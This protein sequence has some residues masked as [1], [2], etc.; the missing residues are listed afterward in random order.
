MKTKLEI[1]LGTRPIFSEEIDVVEGGGERSLLLRVS[2]RLSL[3]VSDA[4]ELLSRG[5]AWRSVLLDNVRAHILDDLT[6]PR[7]EAITFKIERKHRTSDPWKGC[8][9]GDSVEVSALRGKERVGG[10]TVRSITGNGVESGEAFVEFSVVVQKRYRRIGVGSRLYQIAAANLPGPLFP[11][12]D[13]SHLAEFT[14]EKLRREGLVRE[15]VSPFGG[16]S[17][18][19]SPYLCRSNPLPELGGRA[20][21][22]ILEQPRPKGQGSEILP[23]LLSFFS[24]PEGAWLRADLEA[25]TKKGVETYGEPLT[26]ENG[27]DAL[28]DALQEVEDLL[29]YA[30]QIALENEADREA[31]REPRHNAKRVLVVLRMVREFLEGESDAGARL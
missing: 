30:G 15:F 23:F 21:D 20:A 13:H 29:Q 11:D 31:G 7:L 12:P 10:L 1:R 27:R 24:L 26:S 19:L 16:S 8:T 9:V 2:D 5:D 17:E 22:A 3:V 4:R 14:W 6:P 18:A 28:V 25:R